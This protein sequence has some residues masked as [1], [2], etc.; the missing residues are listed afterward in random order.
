M[1][2][3][4]ASNAGVFPAADLIDRAA[5][6]NP[7]GWGLVSLAPRGRFNVRKGLKSDG[8]DAAIAA[9]KGQPYVL[10]FRW[11]THGSVCLDNTHPFKVGKAWMAHNGVLSIDKP[12]KDRSDTWHFAQWLRDHKFDPSWLGDEK[13]TE[14]IENYPGTGNK[15]AFLDHRN[16]MTLLNE[17]LG[18]W[19]GEYWLSN[20]YS[21]HPERDWK[22]SVYSGLFRTSRYSTTADDGSEATKWDWSRCDYCGE[23]VRGKDQIKYFEDTLCPDCMSWIERMEE[24]DNLISGREEERYAAGC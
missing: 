3:I 5:K 6:N 16:G 17:R 24:E 18:K 7:D 2:L 21:A 19:H 15:L 12:T 9:A 23:W 8:L 10:H 4:I 14:T 1:C 13:W 20:E 11:A 22:K